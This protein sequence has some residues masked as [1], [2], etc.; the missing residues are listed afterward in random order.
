M[1]KCQILLVLFIGIQIGVRLPTAKEAA[2]QFKDSLGSKVVDYAAGFMASQ[3]NEAL[4]VPR[5][6]TIEKKEEK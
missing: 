5:K 2:K 6:I 3:I 1:N 4:F